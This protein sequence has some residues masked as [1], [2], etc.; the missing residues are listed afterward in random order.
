[1]KNNFQKGSI[2]FFFDELF[3]DFITEIT[4]REEFSFETIL[5]KEI[6]MYKDKIVRKNISIT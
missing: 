3:F 4:I 6:E 2:S 5:K 1:M